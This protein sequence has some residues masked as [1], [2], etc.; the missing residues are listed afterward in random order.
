MI[1]DPQRKIAAAMAKAR[2]DAMR[3]SGKD[4]E[5]LSTIQLVT[6]ILL[7]AIKT[8]GK[9]HVDDPTAFEQ[10]NFLRVGGRVGGPALAFADAV[11]MATLK[12]RICRVTQFPP[13]DATN[14]VEEAKECHTRLSLEYI[15]GYVGAQLAITSDGGLLYAVAAV[16]VVL[17]PTE[18]QELN[19]D[20]PKRRQALFTQHNDDVVSCE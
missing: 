14:G 11:E 12:S 15:H 16:V 17:Y 3:G 19:A 9:A 20:V 8:L 13:S 10:G 6:M 1:E 4:A 7:Q 5:V 2:A 18:A